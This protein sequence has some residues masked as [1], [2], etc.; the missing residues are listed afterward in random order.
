MTIPLAGLP[1]AQSVS[2]ADIDWILCLELNTNPKFRNWLGRMVF[3][4]EPL[5]VRAWRSVCDP[6]L[7]ESDLLWMVSS[8]DGHARIALL[9]NKINAL[10]QPTQ[11]ERYVLR[12]NQYRDQGFCVECRIVLVSPRE[13][14]SEDSEKYKDRVAYEDIRAF[15]DTL[16]DER[17]EHLCSIFDAALTR[18][19]SLP[20]CPEITAFRRQLWQLAQAEFPQLSIEEPKPTRELWTIKDYG[21]FS[22]KYK[23]T[24]TLGGWHS[25]VDLELPGRAADV[26]QLRTEYGADLKRIGADLVPTGKSA[27]IR[28]KV[29]CAPPPEYD[30]SI[31]RAALNAW[32]KLLTWWREN[33]D[34]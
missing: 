33:N 15:F 12:G 28:L 26:E 29:L 4:F 20:P 2:E 19:S 34:L 16:D 9:E 6:L 23:I 1:F 25:S 32:T 8:P 10:A 24:S 27:A 14:R 18:P 5:H 13:Y 17:G 31:A 11:Y 30:E 22:I 7:G 21:P 3:G